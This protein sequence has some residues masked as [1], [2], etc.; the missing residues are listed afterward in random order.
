MSLKKYQSPL[1]FL[2]QLDESMLV[3]HVN[4]K[5]FVKS[6][7]TVPAKYKAS[8][9]LSA[10]VSLDSQS[11]ILN[12]T[13]LAKKN[14]ATVEEIMETIALAKFAKGATVNSNSVPAME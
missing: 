7:E 1:N 14:G 8:I 12:N 11:C 10:A 9:L 5:K 3:N 2:G 4:D 13:K 6:E